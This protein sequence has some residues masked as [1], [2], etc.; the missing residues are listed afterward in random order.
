MDFRLYGPVPPVHRATQ[1]LYR[2]I[3]LSL[4][5]LQP[6]SEHRLPQAVYRFGCSQFSSPRV[7]WRLNMLATYAPTLL[8]DQSLRAFILDS[9]KQPAIVGRG[10]DPYLQT[11]SPESQDG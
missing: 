11:S 2:I 7:R 1:I 4:T 3:L 9:M 6:R 5:H 8:T 10:I